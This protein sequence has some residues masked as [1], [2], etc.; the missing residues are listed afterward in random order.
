MFTLKKAKLTPTYIESIIVLSFIVVFVLVGNILFDLPF[1]LTLVGAAAGAGLMAWRLGYSWD[2]LETVISKRLQMGTPAILIIW[3]IGAIISTFIFSGSIPMLIFYGMQMIDPGYIYVSAFVTC[4]VF[5]TITGSSY[6]SAGTAGV[7]LMSIAGG[8]GVPLHITAAAVVCGAVFGD[9]LSPLSET[10]NLAAA[11]TGVDLYDHVKSMMWTTFPAAIITF[12]VFLVAGKG[13]NISS[14]EVTLNL[15]LISD[16]DNHY[17]WSLLLLLPFAVILFGAIFKKPPLPIMLLASLIAIIIGVAYQD[18]SLKDGMTAALNGFD[19]SMLPNV[20]T[21]QLSGDTLNLLNRGGMMSLVNVILIIYAGFAYTAIISEAGFLR[22]ALNPLINRVKK[23]GP[24]MV[25]TL[26]SGFV[27]CLSGN[28]YAMTIILPE[29][30][31]K[32]FFKA[33]MHAKTL[34]RS[35]EDVGTVFSTLI[36]WMDSA[37]FFTAVLGIPI[38]GANGWG[39]WAVML[40]I[41]PVIAI[42]L[43]YT[44]IGVYK[45]NS[46]EQEEALAQYELQQKQDAVENNDKT[47]I[48][49]V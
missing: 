8:F 23:R 49:I 18:F 33:G 3:M 28:S 35:I 27:I 30:F 17:S 24:V 46:K 11:A 1:E 19:A 44:G 13:L 22:T 32:S 7:A 25:T 20:I 45:L 9:K 29:M 5:S 42:I 34:S 48:V 31:K 16:L 41:T 4:I 2:E 43:A 14:Q 10:T 40:Y 12:F 15:D 6:T 21:G 38:L 47:S 26:L 39:L 37:V 36:P